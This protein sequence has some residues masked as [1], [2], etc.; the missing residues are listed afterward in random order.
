M[1]EQVETQFTEKNGA[2]GTAGSVT[3][4]L[5]A[6]LAAAQEAEAYY[7]HEKAAARY[8]EA[9]ELPDLNPDEKLAVLNGR[10]TAFRRLG[11]TLNLI[12]DVDAIIALARQTGD[13]EKVASALIVDQTYLWYQDDDDRL[14]YIAET[15]ALGNELGDDRLIAL[16][17]LAKAIGDNFQDRKTTERNLRKALEH[18]R[19]AQDIDVLFGVLVT[20]AENRALF[21]DLAAARE[22][23]AQAREL[24]AESGSLYKMCWAT[25]VS[26]IVEIDLAR[27]RAFF[28]Q[29]IKQ[30][31]TTND[32][33]HLA[34]MSNNYGL[35]MWRLGLYNRALAHAA[36]AVRIDQ[37]L[38][39]RWSYVNDLD[40]LG[41]AYLAK[42]MLAEARE[43]FQRGLDEAGAWP[44]L[45]Y[46]LMIGLARV[47]LASGEY[48]KAIDCLGEVEDGLDPAA[49]LA[50]PV[51]GTAYLALGEAQRALEYTSK[52]I[53]FQEN[54]KDSDEY[55]APEIWWRHYQVLEALGDDNAFDALNRAML[56]MLEAIATLSDEGLR[57]NYLNKVA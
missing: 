15:K 16:S 18:A 22:Y 38:G 54:G 45:Q 41:R 19:R 53:A 26:G 29:A 35:L 52:A 20:Y 30:A 43:A 21:N 14:A 28:E 34:L 7:D 51:L 56:A 11:D 47:L 50:L 57:R 36:K 10:A 40:G 32:Q 1:S 25:S 39:K 24:A 46:F 48:Q 13:K 49:P 37:Q 31:Q 44:N 4:D 27:R 55:P 17:Y 6:L 3:P 2:N 12:K 8:T 5:A 23:A 42:G 9:L 33:G